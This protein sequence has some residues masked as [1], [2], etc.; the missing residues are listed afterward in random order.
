MYV[1]CDKQKTRASV[2]F[3][4]YQLETSAH[5]FPGRSG[6]LKAAGE[7]PS[8]TS[9][10]VCVCVCVFGCVKTWVRVRSYVC[11]WVGSVLCCGVMMDHERFYGHL[12]NRNSFPTWFKM[13]LKKARGYKLGVDAALI[14]T[15]SSRL[16]V[17]SLNQ[18]VDNQSHDFIGLVEKGEKQDRIEATSCCELLTRNDC[19]IL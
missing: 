19:W 5:P 14:E 7:L 11:G 4:K 3:W 8:L 17:D 6:C 2:L 1:H 15:P 18:S 16:L 12:S 13:I 9:W 10:P